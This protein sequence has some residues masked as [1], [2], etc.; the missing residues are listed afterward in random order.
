VYRYITRSVEEGALRDGLFVDF[1]LTVKPAR[2]E[3]STA[4]KELCYRAIMPD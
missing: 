4:R 3:T 1:A 2:G